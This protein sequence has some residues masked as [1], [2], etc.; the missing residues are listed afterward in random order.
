MLNSLTENARPTMG[1]LFCNSNNWSYAI[2]E[3]SNF[4][5]ENYEVFQA[6]KKQNNVYNLTEICEQIININFY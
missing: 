4:T 1:N 5:I 2:M 3:A 6:I